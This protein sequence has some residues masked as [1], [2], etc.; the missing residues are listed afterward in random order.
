MAARI[1]A[2]IE[3][4]ERTVVEQRAQR[5]QGKI[6]DG[7]IRDI[8]S[9]FSAAGYDLREI[10]RRALSPTTK[11]HKVNKSLARISADLSDLLS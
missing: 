7:E 10:T 1:L 5:E 11:D 6:V 4:I 8:L 2:R 3:K 9:I